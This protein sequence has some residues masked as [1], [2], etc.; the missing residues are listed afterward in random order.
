MLIT[1]VL[2]A[3]IASSTVWW[4]STRLDKFG[5]ERFLSTFGMLTGTVSN[6]LI[7]LRITDPEFKTTVSV[8]TGLATSVQLALLMPLYIMYAM[9]PTAPWLG[10]IGLAKI[11]FAHC[12]VFF[13][14]MFIMQK[15]FFK[16]S[17]P[18]DNAK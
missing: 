11:I 18:A 10:T 14:L 6:S 2:I 16:R 8:E 12:V 13:L 3:V 7:L 9:M 4:F 1:V 15:F 17:L 5:L